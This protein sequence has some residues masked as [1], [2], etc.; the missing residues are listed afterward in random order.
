MSSSNTPF[1]KVNDSDKQRPSDGRVLPSEE[2]HTGQG[3]EA[4]CTEKMKLHK[5]K[6][7][8][9]VVVLL[10]AIILAVTLSG[11]GDKPGPT[12][13]PVPPTPPPNPPIPVNRGYNP[14]YLD[15]KSVIV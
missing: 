10:I 8:G 14:Y 3:G 1:M 13:P 11:S 15:E 2:G 9:F 6:I 4:G 12:P 7:I 5:F